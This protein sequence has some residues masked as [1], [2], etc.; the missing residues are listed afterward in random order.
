MPTG[1]NTAEGLSDGTVPTT[2]NT[3]TTSG[4]AASTVSI[5]SGDTLAAKTAAAAHGSVG[6]RFT[7]TGPGTG[8][9]RLMWTMVTS[10]RHVLSTSFRID[11]VPTSTEDIMGLRHSGGNMGVLFIRSDGR[12]QMADT[13]GT[14]IAASVAS[15]AISANTWYQVDMCAKPGTGTGDGTLGYA[16][17]PLGSS[18]PTWTWE[19]AAVNANT[20]ATAV[21]WVGRSTGRAQAHVIDHDT[22]RWDTLASGFMSPFTPTAT[23]IA[24]AGL[25]TT[26]DGYTTVTLDGSSSIGASSYVWTQTAGTTVTLS[27]S[28]ATRTFT[29]PGLLAPETLGFQ[30]SINSGASTDTVA[31]A[32]R[33]ATA[34]IVKASAWVPVE[35]RRL[36]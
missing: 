14:A 18:T 8:P 13:T 29:A 6:Y 10:L 15:T 1:S 12:I 9:T 24:D 2:A 11:S 33:P 19:S 31:V 34:R 25:D 16:V 27:G 36:A 3:G 26:V 22:I 28:G 17:Y 20:A 23:V 4:D 32:V 21:G 35:I 30:L 7:L 5:A